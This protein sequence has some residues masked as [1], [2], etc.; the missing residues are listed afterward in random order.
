MPRWRRS[1][2]MLLAFYL[3]IL[4]VGILLLYLLVPAEVW[5]AIRRTYI[6]PDE[7]LL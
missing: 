2:L 7:G 1:L 4:L 3:L 6:A 5:D